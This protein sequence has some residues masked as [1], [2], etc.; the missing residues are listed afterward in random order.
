M[1][2]CLIFNQLQ[3]LKHRKK[4]QGDEKNLQNLRSETIKHLPPDFSWPKVRKQQANLFQTAMGLSQQHFL[5]TCHVLPSDYLQ[6]YHQVAPQILYST[7]Q[8]WNAASTSQSGSDS[9]TPSPGM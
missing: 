2:T 8:V 4:V 5:S 7:P 3:V 6:V 1:V 9:S